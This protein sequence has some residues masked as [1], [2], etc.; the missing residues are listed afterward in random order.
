MTDIF[1]FI[2]SEKSFVLVFF[3]PRESLSYVSCYF[4]QWSRVFLSHSIFE[5]GSLS[6]FVKYQFLFYST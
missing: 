1:F 6:D 5:I 2:F 4:V 3:F